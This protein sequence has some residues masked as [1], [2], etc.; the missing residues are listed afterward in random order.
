MNNTEWKKRDVLKIIKSQ[1]EFIEISGKQKMVLFRGIKNCLGSGQKQKIWEKKG[2]TKK[3]NLKVAR[4]LMEGH[5]E[6]ESNSEIPTEKL[7][8]EIIPTVK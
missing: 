2:L 6:Y 7:N 1:N 3:G 5:E 8:R 4:V